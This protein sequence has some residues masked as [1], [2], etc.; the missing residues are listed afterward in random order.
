MM[1]RIAMPKFSK[2]LQKEGEIQQPS[3]STAQSQYSIFKE[4]PTAMDESPINPMKN[5]T[6]FSASKYQFCAV[7]SLERENL[8]LESIRE[9]PTRTTKY[10]KQGRPLSAKPKT[11]QKS[12]LLKNSP[13]ISLSNKQD[14][15]RQ[16]PQMTKV[17][18]IL[19]SNN[20]NCDLQ[21]KS[22]DE[23]LTPQSE[24]AKLKSSLLKL[25]MCYGDF[26]S[27]TAATSISHS[28]FLKI[29][30]ESK[31]KIAVK[32]SLSIMMST[33]L[34]TKTNIVKSITF[35]Q[36]LSLLRPLAELSFVKTYSKSPKRALKKLIQKHLLPLLRRIESKDAQYSGTNSVFTSVLSTLG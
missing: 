17:K 6:D 13:S 35:D 20:S 18:I 21:L 28:S 4:S 30:E 16:T 2:T 27:K 25:F 22:Q 5:S 26:N 36:F 34:Q 15:S 12:K 11:S 31:V 33:T 3:S 8:Y 10:K 14:S 9:I 7:E 24:L 23:D 29:V 32:N 19:N 1:Q